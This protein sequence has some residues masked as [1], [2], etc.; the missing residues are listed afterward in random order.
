MPSWF[1]KFAERQFRKTVKRLLV[2]QDP[3]VETLERN[4]PQTIIDGAYYS[5]WVSYG[6]PAHGLSP[7]IYRSECKKA[8]LHVSDFYK[9]SAEALTNL[10][11]RP[12]IL[13]QEEIQQPL[14]EKI[15]L[16]NEEKRDLC[17][18]MSDTLLNFM[19]WQDKALEEVCNERDLSDIGSKELVFL[20]DATKKIYQN[21]SEHYVVGADDFSILFVTAAVKF[22]DYKDVELEDPNPIS[23]YYNVRSHCHD[24]NFFEAGD[25]FSVYAEHGE[26]AQCRHALAWCYGLG[27]EPNYENLL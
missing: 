25:A 15:K 8:A 9:L 4:L 5:A 7:S 10:A 1:D 22:C 6:K 14:H 21:A 19:V 16:N 17:R 23:L 11:Q 27:D 12:P 3:Y 24:S 26:Q 13:A 18:E 2:E 20:Y